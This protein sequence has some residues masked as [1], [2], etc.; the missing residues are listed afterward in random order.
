GL[1]Y[2]NPRPTEEENAKFYHREYWGQYKSQSEPNE[3]F[4]N[5]RLPKIKSMLS[6]ISENLRP[7]MRV[8]EIGSGA[9]ALLWSIKR[10]C[11]GEGEFI[12]VE[13]HVGHAKFCRERKKLDVR[14]GLLEEV[15]P[16]LPNKHFDLVVMNHVLEHTVSPTWVFET[17]KKLLKPD[18]VFVVE[19]PNVAAPGSRLSHFFHVAHHFNFSPR[20]LQHLAQKTGYSVNRVN[21]LDGDLP[22]TRLF[23]IFANQRSSKSATTGE[24]KDDP[25]ERANALNRYENWYWRTLASLRKK[26]THW[27]RQRG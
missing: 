11:N 12:G 22:D 5:R 19:V 18:G 6:E 8:L 16:A 2:S 13:P 20:T 25:Q 15:V 1:V 7:G 4:F 3:K 21:E 27:Q 23:G 10:N 14:S 24:L 26:I 9:G 17:V